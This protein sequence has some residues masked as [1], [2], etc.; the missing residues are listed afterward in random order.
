MPIYNFKCDSCDSVTELFRKI[1]DRDNIESEK[2]PKC[3]IIGDL[4]RQI[5]TVLIGYN[6]YINGG[7]KPPQG[8]RDRLHQIHENCPGSQLDK[9]SSFW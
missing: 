2:C 6:T 1:V 5:G 7:G 3:G 8:F 4:K 9:T